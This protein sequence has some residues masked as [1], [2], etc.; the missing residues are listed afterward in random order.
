MY[1]S[2]LDD[3]RPGSVGRDFLGSLGSVIVPLYRV[4]QDNTRPTV[5]GLASFHIPAGQSG[6][7]RQR[8][9][10]G[11]SGDGYIPSI[12]RDANIQGLRSL[13]Q[14]LMGEWRLSQER[15]KR[16]HSSAIS[17]KAMWLEAGPVKTC[18]VEPGMRRCTSNP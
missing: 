16:F 10:A 15:V 14:G 7:F 3:G 8:G 6:F 18:I 2:V 9:F 5:R 13:F 4:D 12:N 1:R 11:G 17:W